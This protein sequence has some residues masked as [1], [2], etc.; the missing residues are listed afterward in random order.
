MRTPGRPGLKERL[1]PVISIRDRAESTVTGE[2]AQS[3]PTPRKSG[4]TKGAL[5]REPLGVG[6]LL[7]ACFPVISVEVK[8]RDESLKLKCFIWGKECN[9]CVS[10]AWVV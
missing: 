2:A 1:L 5:R 4:L 9:L 3:F 10:V 8:Y 7:A 6:G